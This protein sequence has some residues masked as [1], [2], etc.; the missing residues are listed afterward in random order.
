[1]Y[2]VHSRA[3]KPS[4]LRVQFRDT[5]LFA[6]ECLRQHSTGCRFRAGGDLFRRAAG[7][8]LPPGLRRAGANI[9][10]PVGGFHHLHVARPHLKRPARGDVRWQ[11]LLP[12]S[13]MPALTV[14]IRPTERGG[15][16]Q[17]SAKTPLDFSAYMC[18]HVHYMRGLCAIGNLK[19]NIRN[20]AQQSPFPQPPG[21]PMPGGRPVSFDQEKQDLFCAMIRTGCSRAAAARAVGVCPRTIRNTLATN[22]AFCEQFRSA[23]SHPRL[24]ALDDIARAA[25]GNWRAAA[26]L[27]AYFDRVQRNRR[28]QQP[29][30]DALESWD[31]I[32]LQVTTAETELEPPRGGA[33]CLPEP[34]TETFAPPTPAPPTFAPDN[35]PLTAAE[36][37]Q[38]EFPQ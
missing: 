2:V 5:R 14:T 1:M 20:P 32:L 11:F 3:R 36:F 28:R 31:A 26:W 16:K 12:A 23:E 37:P 25:R 27:V 24:R 15:G 21:A 9:K 4:R 7:D 35:R 6:R 10:Y 17:K 22:A 34:A 29:E 19:S 38:N 13:R 8:D 30:K 33:A 18:S